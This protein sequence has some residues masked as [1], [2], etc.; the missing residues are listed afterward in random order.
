MTDEELKQIIKDN[1][2]TLVN[3]DERMHRIEKKFIWNSIFGFIKTIVILAPII[4]GIIYL[5]PILRDYIKIFEPIFKNLPVTL[6]NMSNASEQINIDA[7]ESNANNQ[8]STLESFCDP[9]TR[10]QMVEQF[11]K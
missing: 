5:T 1:K 4:V 11:C 6:Q 10:Q 3:I 2:E 8:T 9:Q 7:N